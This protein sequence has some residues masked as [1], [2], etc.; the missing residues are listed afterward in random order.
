LLIR[1][2]NAEQERLPQVLV[3]G[4]GERAL[5]LICVP[6]F[7]GEK[8]VGVISVQAYRPYAFGEA[9][10]ELLSTIADT[11]AVAVDN[12]RLYDAAQ[13]HADDLEQRVADRTHELTKAYDHLRDLDRLKDQFISRISHELRTPLANIQLYLSLLD[14]GK[15]DKRQE[16]VQTL[17]SE[18]ARLNKLIEDMLEISQFDTGQLSIQVVPVDL[19]RLVSNLC[20]DWMATATERGLTFQ[21]EPAPNLK[22]VLAHSSLLTRAVGN[23]I[24]NAFSYTP[25]GG[26]VIC[27][28]AICLNA[29]VEW[30][31]VAVQDTGPGISP[32]ERPHLFERFYRGRAA[33]NYKVP[34]TGLGLAIAQEIIDRFDGRITV[35]DRPDASGAIFTIWLRSA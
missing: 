33:R 14:S 27:C 1:D 21:F 3:W 8:V 31:T 19:N 24:S 9:E 35:D 6:M 7:L 34:G 20:P 15:P 25:R 28:T 23:L 5:S 32:E 30:V 22:P 26:Q 2:L 16:Y 17:R 18:T 29:G 4:T 11:V 13:R 12:A 10:L